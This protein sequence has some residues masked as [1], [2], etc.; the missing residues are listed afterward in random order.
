MSED[1]FIHYDDPFRT[2]ADQRDETKRLRGAL[3]RGVTIWTSGSEDSPAGLTM[4][5]VLLADGTPAEVLGL[6]SDTTALYETIGATGR[7]VMHILPTEAEN[8]ADI[9]AGLRPA[10]GGPFAHVA[11]SASEHGPVIT[12][13]VT[14]A[15]CS[16]TS[17][18]EVGYQ[19]L[20]R[21]RID[22]IA[23]TDPGEPLVHYRGRY[24]KL[25]PGPGHAPG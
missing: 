19:R 23:L 10:P 7:F 15:F 18:I 24:R 14:R 4:S 1:A 9:F 5:S 20:V 3:V 2:P 13:L 25:E 22:S 12:E 6:I 8:L 16:V 11:W 17:D 21:G